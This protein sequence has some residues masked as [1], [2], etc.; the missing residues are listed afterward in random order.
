M[1]VPVKWPTHP[2]GSVKKRM[3]TKL[4]SG[5]MSNQWVVESG[6]A[7]TSPLLHSTS[8]TFPSS[9]RLFS[10]VPS[11]FIRTSSLFV[12]SHFFPPFPFL[13]LFF[14]LLLLSFFL[15]LFFFFF[16]FFF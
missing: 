1:S 10:P 13:L 15:L 7:I 2:S 9:F 4:G 5:P 16:L 14:F 11:T 12:I 3:A 8:L 6:T